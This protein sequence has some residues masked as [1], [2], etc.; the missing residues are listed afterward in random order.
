MRLMKA[1]VL[2][3]LA[4]LMMPVAG[5]EASHSRSHVRCT[6]PAKAVCPLH[7]HRAHHHRK[8]HHHHVRYVWVER[9][10]VYAYYVPRTVYRPFHYSSWYHP[11]SGIYHSPRPYYHRWYGWR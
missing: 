8:H 3:L 5:A 2:A 7:R 1:A 4:M 11:Y 10:A 6:A 9:P